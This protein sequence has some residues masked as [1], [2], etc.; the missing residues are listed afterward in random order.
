[1]ERFFFIIAVCIICTSGYGI[2]ESVRVVNN[3]LQYKVPNEAGI[4]DTQWIVI[5][6][7]SQSRNKIFTKKDECSRYCIEGEDNNSQVQTNLRNNK[8]NFIWHIGEKLPEFSSNRLPVDDGESEIDNSSQVQVSPEKC[9]IQLS[10]GCTNPTIVVEEENTNELEI[11]RNISLTDFT[12]NKFTVNPGVHHM[13]LKIVGNVTW[14]LLAIPAGRNR[15]EPLGLSLTRDNDSNGVNLVAN[16][17]PPGGWQLKL[18]GRENSKYSLTVSQFVRVEKPVPLPGY[19]E[20]ANLDEDTDSDGIVI[21]FEDTDT[22]ES[23]QGPLKFPEESSDP[24]ENKNYP[25]TVVFREPVEELSKL[26]IEE[27][28]SAELRDLSRTS[29]LITRRQLVDVAPETALLVPRTPF[30]RIIFTVTNNQ[31]ISIVHQ[32]QAKCPQ[33]QDI[34]TFLPLALVPPHTTIRISVQFRVLTMEDSVVITLHVNRQY[35][36]PIEKSAYIYFQSSPNAISD[37]T[38][39]TIDYEFNNNCAGRLRQDRCENNFWTVDITVTD[40]NSGLK[41]VTSQP[42]GVR[43]NREFIAGT[44]NPV[45]FVYTGS[46]CDTTVEITAKDVVGNTH[47]RT[48]DVTAWDNLSTGEIAAIVVSSLFLLFIIVLLILLCVYCIRNRKSADISYSQRYGSRGGP[49]SR[50]EGTNF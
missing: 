31:P 8:I 32:F 5:N 49:G 43:P 4:D 26:Q 23:R 10:I 38:K 13:Q 33:C 2:N 37:G 18:R 1:M 16:N 19:E 44:R 9:K 48:L 7:T 11:L 25:R 21:F 3:V 17:P 34:G 47:S 27:N 20:D 15:A 40:D 45:H 41:R 28:A 46:C 24:E 29:D 35:L 6:R 22:L 50:T 14:M 36:D 12:S 42:S 39:P 30:H